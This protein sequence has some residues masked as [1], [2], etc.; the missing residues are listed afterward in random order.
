MSTAMP[1]FI[2]FELAS[3]DRKLVVLPH[4]VLSP[5]PYLHGLHITVLEQGEIHGEIMRTYEL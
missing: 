2:P 1:G 3:A 5:V 4:T